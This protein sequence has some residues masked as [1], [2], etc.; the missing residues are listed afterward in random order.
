[1]SFSFINAEYNRLDSSDW[2][3]SLFSP[4]S[5][6]CSSN[7][8]YAPCEYSRAD[9]GCQTDICTQQSPSIPRSFIVSPFAGIMSAEDVVRELNLFIKR[10]S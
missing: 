10:Q 7:C 6:N 9:K 4:N 8:S 5:Y 2:D 3:F 1:M